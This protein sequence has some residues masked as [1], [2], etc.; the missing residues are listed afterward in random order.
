MGRENRKSKGRA[1]SSEFT[2]AA[3]L[4]N[5][6]FAESEERRKKGDKTTGDAGY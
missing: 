4:Q 6:F 3:D 1:R 2:N 5:R